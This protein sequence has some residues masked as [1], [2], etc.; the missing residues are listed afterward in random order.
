MLNPNKGN[1]HGVF[2]YA[3]KRRNVFDRGN[4][5]SR[6]GGGIMKRVHNTKQVIHLW[7]HQ[8]QTDARNAANSVFF[9][10]PN[11]FSYGRHYLMGRIHEVNGKR[12]A[13][14]NSLGYS[15][16]TQKHTS[17]AWRALNGVMPA[18]YSPDPRDAK[19]TIKYLDGIA[20]ESVLLPLKRLKVTDRDAI[21]REFERIHD[22]YKDAST[23]RKILGR[24]EVWPK[25]KEL[26]K[27]QAHLEKRLSRWEE[28]NT[29]EML[30]KR[31]EAS[32]KRAE[33]KERKLAEAE[34]K[35]RLETIER[36]AK[37]KA[38]ENIQPVP[39]TVHS[40][41]R[42]KGDVIQ[43]NGGAEVPLDVARRL[44]VALKNGMNIVGKHVGPFEINGIYETHNDHTIKIGCH[45]ILLSE[46]EN[47]LGKV[48]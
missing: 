38:G 43:T 27:V 3:Y 44:F 30:A 8:A 15:V 48:G 17:W 16:T 9:D 40:L 12:F 4:D 21:K 36:L 14:I 23:L 10:G 33:A 35:Y 20:A 7:A 19:A 5:G 39:H 24:A 6:N 1:T 22:A 41:L 31:S 2:K 46:I 26:D 34:E 45:L 29:P 11:L 18:F 32:V 13:L 42:I 37:W 28:L 25:R 47:V